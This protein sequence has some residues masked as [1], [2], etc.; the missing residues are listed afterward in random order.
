MKH[1]IDSSLS[2]LSEALTS[3]CSNSSTKF[4]FPPVME[5]LSS[6]SESVDDNI[7]EISQEK[8]E[9]SNGNRLSVKIQDPLG[10][11][12]ELENQLE[13][14]QRSIVQPIQHE[15]A[16]LK[17][18]RV[19]AIESCDIQ[20][21]EIVLLPALSDLSDHGQQPWEEDNCQKNSTTTMSS[22]EAETS[23]PNPLLDQ[24]LRRQTEY[25]LESMR[26]SL[27]VKKEWRLFYAFHLERFRQLHSAVVQQYHDKLVQVDA[28]N[29]KLSP[30]S[31]RC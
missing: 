8:T 18:N 24:S 23:I 27:E 17:S 28:K 4:N 7:K 12:I 3:P 1:F 15:I 10:K 29:K 25:E 31:S 20:E 13:S 14:I 2:V 16:R 5:K 21:V 6:S 11:C 26:E 19:N 9:L 30:I 22:L